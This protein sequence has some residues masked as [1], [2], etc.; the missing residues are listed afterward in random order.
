M[1]HPSIGD[2]INRLSSEGAYPVFGVCF[3][4]YRLRPVPDLSKRSLVQAH[5]YL[6]LPCNSFRLTA[7]RLTRQIAPGRRPTAPVRRE[8]LGYWCDTWASLP[9]AAGA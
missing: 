9:T 5:L 2:L 7:A 4:G 1:S 6:S 8:H 3:R